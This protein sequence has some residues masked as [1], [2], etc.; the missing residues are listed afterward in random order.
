MSQTLNAISEKVSPTQ[1]ARRQTGRVKDRF[2]GI[3]AAVMGSAENATQSVQGAAGA[4]GEKA[5][6]LVQSVQQAP[7]AA[8]AQ[9]QGNPLAAGLVA[10]GLGLLAASVIPASERERQ[11]AAKVGETA[12]PAVQQ[13]QTV[14]QEVKQNLQEN[15]Q[16]ALGEVKQAATSATQEM[17]DQ[18]ASSAQEVG[19]TARQAASDVG[20]Q[21]KHSAQGSTPADEAPR[22]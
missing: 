11:L 6:A 18:A 13:A 2:A 22:P 15:A 9:A 1:M 4:T 20:E 7:Q 5:G 21:A 3:R 17:K 12:Q 16:S 19:Q 14:A 10:F 8:K